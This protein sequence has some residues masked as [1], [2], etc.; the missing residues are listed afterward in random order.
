MLEPVVE[1][2]TVVA[3]VMLVVAA[4]PSVLHCPLVRNNVWMATASLK[5][6]R[7]NT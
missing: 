3:T 4:L 2:L 7:D 1:L 5:T 6:S